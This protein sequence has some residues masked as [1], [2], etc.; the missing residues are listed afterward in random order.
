MCV[1]VCMFVYIV[2]YFNHKKRVQER[3]LCVLKKHTRNESLSE[4]LCEYHQKNLC[5]NHTK[6]KE[7]TFVCT[8]TKAY[9]CTQQ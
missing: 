8:T 2:I 4:I 9:M 7:V 6:T 3:L 5:V 1:C